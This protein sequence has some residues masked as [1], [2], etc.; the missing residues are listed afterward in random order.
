MSVATY[1]PAL[2][3][4]TPDGESRILLDRPSTTIGRSPTQ[5]LV[6]PESFVSRQHALI[7][8]E[9]HT[10]ELID[11]NS[12]HGTYLNGA[13]IQRA[14]LNPGDTI[15]CGSPNA[16][17]L[18][19]HLQRT[20]E[21]GISFLPTPV[22]DLLST[23]SNFQPPDDA[24]PAGPLEQL[25]FL[26][27][28]ARQLN[29]GGAIDD[30]LRAL[31]QLTLKLTGVE[32]GFVFLRKDGEMH[33]A[34]GLHAN[35]DPVEEDAT[36]SRRA[37][38][39]AIESESNFLISDTMTDH[40]AS[41]WA[42]VMVNKIRSIYCLPLR[43]RTAPGEPDH[44]LGLLYL[45]SQLKPGN[46]SEVDHQLLD[47]V[48]TEAAALLHNVLLADAEN[49][50][51][52]AREELAIAAQIHTSLMSI[53]LPVLPYA[54]LKGRSK[55][56]HD[57]GG[58]FYDAVAL[59]SASGEHDCVCVTMADVSGKGVSAAIVAATLQGIIHALML[60]RQSLPEIAAL[61]NQFLCTRQVGK[62]ATMVMLK[63]YPDG[64]L[65][66][67]NCGHIQPVLV[68]GE[69]PTRQLRRLEDS[70]LV[71]GLIDTATYDSTFSTSAPTSASS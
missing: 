66:Y 48:A 32:R 42:S 30:I 44:L 67:L 34:L 19:F 58:D 12:T 61:L 39:R 15:Q 17:K 6:L 63:L 55:P 3:Y 57:I 27:S 46:L 2:S 5:D 33:L 1:V 29:A 71:V 49:F 23:L 43:K 16:P 36:V 69:G 38:A 13:R 22:S 21:S 35:G 51:R 20:G 9:G 41:A 54:V 28:A 37:I 7:S 65:E 11:Q 53:K 62:Y 70:N 24:T 59:T 10:Y 40:S 45:D 52:K 31:L 56:C 50:A 14:A 8:R 47:A 64:R 4:A 18:R 25:N 26:L 68:H 60:T